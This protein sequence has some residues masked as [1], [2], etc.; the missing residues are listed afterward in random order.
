MKIYRQGHMKRELRGR[1]YFHIVGAPWGY[2]A[3]PP[4]HPPQPLFLVLLLLLILLL[5]FPCFLLIL[6]CLSFRRD[7]APQSYPRAPICTTETNAHNCR[8]THLLAPP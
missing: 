1:V 7:Q 6:L 4:P 2:T 3:R 8:D 5:C